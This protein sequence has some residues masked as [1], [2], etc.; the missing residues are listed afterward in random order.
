MNTKIVYVTG[1]LGFIGYYVA[2]RCLERD[3]H[4]L[5]VD[6]MTYAANPALLERLKSYPKFKFLKED[7]AELDHLYDCDYVINVAAESHVDNSIMS[8]NEFLRSNVNG[9]HNLLSLIRSKSLF[10]MPTLIHFSTDE[11]YGD[12]E[13][14]SHTEKDL[15]KQPR[16]QQETCLF[17]P[18]IGLMAYHT[19][20]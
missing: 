20:W 18:G 13:E 19:T 4:V 17:W 7:I 10:D 11:V 5:G 6:K 2:K 1:C 12:I 15:L 3:W 16:K 9:V 14:G 8:S